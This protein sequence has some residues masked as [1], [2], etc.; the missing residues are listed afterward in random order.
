MRR[1]AP[2]LSILFLPLSIRVTVASES[3]AMPEPP[4]AR[5]VPH[6]MTLHGH[7]RSDPYHWMRERGTPAVLAN[8]GAL[9]GVLGAV[10]SFVAPI[11]LIAAKKLGP[12]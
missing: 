4:V 6:R 5:K 9:D 11:V 7:T 1:L 12:V 2:I 10:V 3:A 8:V